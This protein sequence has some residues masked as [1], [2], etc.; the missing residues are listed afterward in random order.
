MDSTFA[1][2]D[3]NKSFMENLP[4]T[5]LNAATNVPVIGNVAS[6]GKN[7]IKEKNLLEQTLIKLQQD[8]QQ[9]LFHSVLQLSI[10]LTIQLQSF[11]IITLELTQIEQTRSLKIKLETCTMMLWK[12]I[13]VLFSLILNQISTIIY[14]ISTA[15]QINIY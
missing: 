9:N 3:D 6:L 14:Q 4:M 1:D 5:T 7:Y 12:N 11:L 10:K 2:Y 13:N 8:L 15:I